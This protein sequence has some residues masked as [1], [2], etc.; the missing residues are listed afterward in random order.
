MR[1]T[2]LNR[3]TR[4]RGRKHLLLVVGSFNHVNH[5]EEVPLAGEIQ[6]TCG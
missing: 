5:R 2:Y 3:G 4:S 6:P 1:W